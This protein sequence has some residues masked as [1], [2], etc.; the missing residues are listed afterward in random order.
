[1]NDICEN[2]HGGNTESLEANDYIEPGKSTLR[3]QIVAFLKANPDG[4]IMEEIAAAL[5][6]KHQTASPRC[7][8]LKQMGVVVPRADNGK[9]I[10]RNTTS[11]CSA[12][13]L[14]LTGLDLDYAEAAWEDAKRAERRDN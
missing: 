11:G 8:E 2:N 1:M 3:R 6:L 13:V 12:S 9:P 14:V 10:R 7:T 5:R 4:K